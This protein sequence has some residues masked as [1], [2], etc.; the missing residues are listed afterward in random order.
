MKTTE[1]SLEKTK[2]SGVFAWLSLALGIL[3]YDIYAI[4]SSKIETLTRSFWRLSEKESIG[5]IFIGVWL[6]LTFHLLIEK[7]VRKKIS[8]GKK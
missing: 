8:K 2:T 6:G 7:S 4:K 5:I 3:A 1:F